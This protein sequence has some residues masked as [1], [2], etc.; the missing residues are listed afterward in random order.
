MEGYFRLL[1][2]TFIQCVTAF[3]K[4]GYPIVYKFMTEMAVGLKW[5]V[6]VSSFG[7]WILVIVRYFLKKVSGELARKLEL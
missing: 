2:I 5:G 6:I 1:F 3:I 4:L 7:F